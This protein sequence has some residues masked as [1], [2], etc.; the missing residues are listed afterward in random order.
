MKMIIWFRNKYYYYGSIYNGIS[1]LIWPQM[2]L[3]CDKLQMSNK[4]S[5][6]L[7][8]SDH[9]YKL[10]HIFQSSKSLN[11][12]GSLINCIILRD[13]GFSLDVEGFTLVESLLT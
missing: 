6:M 7:L 3:K 10:A 9:I 4:Q 13:A 8:H 11:S 5:L 2:I 1:S 12:F